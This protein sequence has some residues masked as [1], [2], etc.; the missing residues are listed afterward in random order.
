MWPPDFQL[1]IFLGIIPIVH[2]SK[3]HDNDKGASVLLLFSFI[4]DN[5]VLEDTGQRFQEI[6]GFSLTNIDRC[7]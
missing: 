6:D 5:F 7:S 2:W 4:R 3:L 1:I